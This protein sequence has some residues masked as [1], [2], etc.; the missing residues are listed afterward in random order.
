MK[1]NVLFVW[2]ICVFVVFPVIVGFLNSAG[3]CWREV[4]LILCLNSVFRFVVMSDLLEPVDDGATSKVS[5]HSVINEHC[6]L[7]CHL[8]L[9]KVNC[10]DNC[11]LHLL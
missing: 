11:T 3:Y 1:I 7:A 6:L 10:N 8:T 9:S 4:W 2:I 5:T